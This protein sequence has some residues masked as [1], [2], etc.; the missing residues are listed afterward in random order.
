VCL[1]GLYVYVKEAILYSS[2]YNVGCLL[3]MVGWLR[4]QMLQE[5]IN[6]CFLLLLNKQ[7][8]MIIFSLLFF[9]M[10]HIS[11]VIMYVGIYLLVDICGRTFFLLIRKGIDRT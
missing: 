3:P 9:V 11:R 6:E 2:S 1:F 5:T 7:S 8:R 4:R 10:C